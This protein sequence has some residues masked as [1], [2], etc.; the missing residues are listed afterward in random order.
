VPSHL[1]AP[2]RRWA[3]HLL[4]EYPWTPSEWRLVILAAETYDRAATARRTLQREGLTITSPRGELKPH[5]CVL[6]A[7]DSTAL[8]SKL[9]AQLGIDQGD[10][11]DEAPRV[12]RRYSQHKHVA[13]QP[14]ERKPRRG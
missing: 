3:Q 6:I 5:P 11:D 10:D 8:F 13:R 7:R 2:T 9:L 14:A 4:G 1:A 12:D